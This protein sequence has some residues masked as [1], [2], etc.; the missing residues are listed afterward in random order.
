MVIYYDSILRRLLSVEDRIIHNPIESSSMVLCMDKDA[1]GTNISV[2][3]DTVNGPITD[4][5]T[6]SVTYADVVRR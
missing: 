5:K 1:V 4:D 2:K 3:T 6:K